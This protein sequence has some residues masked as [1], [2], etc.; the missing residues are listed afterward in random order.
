MVVWIIGKSGSGKTFLAQNLV[1]EL[2]KKYKKVLRVDGDVFRKKFSKD[3]GYSLAD[4]KKNS[5]R[6]QNYCRKYELKNY[7]VICSILSIF[8]KHQKENRKIF[9]NYFQVYVDVKTN[10]LKKRNSKKIYS[11]NSN[12]VG[13]DI[14]FPTPYKS[15]L[16]IKNNFN[17][18]YLKNVRTIKRIINERI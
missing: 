15:D 5:K 17:K 1:K 3:L 7:I 8:Q 2:K 4:R 12:V 13:A 16:K 18:N 10:T 14:K 6:I 9:K 11:Y